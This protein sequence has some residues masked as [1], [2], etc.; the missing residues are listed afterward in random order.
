MPTNPDFRDLFS[1]LNDANAR[2]LVVGAYAVIHYT[3]PRYTKD[4]N[5]WIEP[6]RENAQA[7]YR[8]LAAFGAP[9]EQV[10]V[11][12]LAN[13]DM[14]YQIGIEPNRIDIIMDLDC[15]DF[16]TAYSHAESTSYGGVPIRLLAIDDL[17]AAKRAAGRDQDLLDLTKLEMA[18]LRPNKVA[19]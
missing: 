10:G 12:D 18:R 17:I 2:F 9:L 14:V 16:A 11:D 6:T 8:A 5:I 4:L 13:P 1:A 15:L 7:V 3:E 19:Q